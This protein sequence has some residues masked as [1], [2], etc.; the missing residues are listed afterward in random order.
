[1]KRKVS[2]HYFLAH[3]DIR[4][5]VFED[6]DKFNQLLNDGPDALKEYFY[7]L[8]N[9]KR[10]DFQDRYDLDVIDYDKEIS[11]DDFGISYSILDNGQKVFNFLMPKPLTDYGQAIYISIVITSR[12]PRFFTLEFTNK[13]GTSAYL[14]GEW[15]I[16]FDNNDYMHKNYGTIDEPE[17]GKFLGKINDV[18][19]KLC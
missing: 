10:K 8:W 9:N 16:D 5:L 15:Q 1:M 19:M 11:K 2:I 14:V 13:N 4:N 18:I 6:Y 3:M 12:I 7:L 17:I